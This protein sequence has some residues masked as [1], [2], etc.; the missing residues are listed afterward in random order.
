LNLVDWHN[1]KVR[2][3][4]RTIQAGLLAGVPHKNDG[5]L[6]FGPVAKALATARM[7]V[8]PDPSSSAPLLTKS[9]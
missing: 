7:D 4:T 6:G 1:R 9:R 2:V 3:I 8:D 5:S